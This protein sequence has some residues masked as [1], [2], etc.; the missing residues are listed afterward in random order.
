VVAVP[1]LLTAAY[2]SRV[3]LPA[4]IREAAAVADVAPVVVWQADVLGPD[5][6]LL[7]ALERRIREAGVWPRD[8]AV[9]V[10][11]A[12]AGSSDPA[13]IA[14]VEHVASNWAQAGWA[15]VVPAYSSAASPTPAQAVAT[16]RDRGIA[17][18]VVASYLLAPGR[19][20]DTLHDAGGDV[21]TA[22]LGAAPEVV[23]LVVARYEQAAGSPAL[24]RSTG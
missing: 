23:R 3:D 16:L 4:Q 20:A 9:G 10:V 7:A 12:A 5:R 2:H 22:P 17:R 8:T 24:A 14:T 19:F 11:L 15:A 21:V 6:L 13:A 1:L 18:V